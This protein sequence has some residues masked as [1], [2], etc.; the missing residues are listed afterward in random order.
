VLVRAKYIAHHCMDKVISFF[1]HDLKEL[2]QGAGDQLTTWYLK[3]RENCGLQVC[4]IESRD[5]HIR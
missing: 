2:P 4:N 5:N 1:Y 3:A